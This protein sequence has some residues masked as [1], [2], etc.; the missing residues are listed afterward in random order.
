MGRSRSNA[1]RLY[2]EQI[3]PLLA[4]A[5]KLSEEHGQPFVAQ[6]EYEPGH[7][8]LTA[9]LGPRPSLTMKMVHWAALA[10]TNVDTFMVHLL[11]HVD[12]HGH[13]SIF[14]AVLQRALE[15]AKRPLRLRGFDGHPRR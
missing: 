2:D 5:A 1:E 7:F 11:R 4:Q 12:E 3:A 14:L 10:K 13:S 15:E 6:V 8:G 9:A